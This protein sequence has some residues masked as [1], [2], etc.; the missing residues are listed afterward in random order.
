MML[1]N[2]DL[3]IL[4]VLLLSSILII[5]FFTTLVKNNMIKI[6]I[7]CLGLSVFIYS[8]YGIAYNTVENHF[9]YYYIVYLIAILAPVAYINR[10]NVLNTTAETTLDS[11]LIHSRSTVALFAYIYLFCIA[12]PLFYPNFQLFDALTFKMNLMAEF[13]DN[14]RILKNSFVGIIDYLSNLVLPFFFIYL[15]RLKNEGKN[16]KVLALILLFI[17]LIYGRILYLARNQML[18]FGVFLYITIFALKNSKIH[19]NRKHI[20]VLV[21]ILMLLVPFLFNYTFIRQGNSSLNISYTEI[22]TLLLESETGYPE[23]YGMLENHVNKEFGLINFILWI[24]CLP[25]PSFVWHTKPAPV[26]NDAFTYLITGLNRGDVGY[27][28]LL[29]SIMGEGLFISGVSFFWLHALLIGTIIG[30]IF[31]YLT[32]HKTLI[33]YSIYMIIL[34]LTLGRGGSGSY[35]PSLINTS[36]AIVLFYFIKMKT[37]G[38]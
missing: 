5:L 31:R 4:I 9:I 36:V 16:K 23:Y 13:F 1:L 35:I 14:K 18:V 15:A 2:L 29:P 19:I 25:I 30:I 24:I 12:V 27:V 17:F 26:W 3:N 22:L 32:R 34:S 6:L 28:V 7:V 33:V 11:L 21:S 20:F 37:N 8:G 38:R 10:R